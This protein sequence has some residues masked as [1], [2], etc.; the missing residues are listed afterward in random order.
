[1]KK[2]VFVVALLVVLLAVSIGPVSAQEELVVDP[3][4]TQESFDMWAAR[5]NVIGQW[6]VV[7]VVVAAG[8]FLA[9]RTNASLL[10]ALNESTQ[11]VHES[12]MFTR[13]EESY[14]DL[15]GTI[16]SAIEGVEVIA[17]M[18]K[19]ILP[20]GPAEELLGTVL[21]TVDD[22]QDGPE[23]EDGV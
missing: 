3:D 14:A 7:L 5:I 23:P 2:L 8:G 4:L 6:M 15:P 11:R 16:T 18:L 10:K 1:M 19:E 12:Q 9:F 17:R 13:L 22:L 20:D 21:E